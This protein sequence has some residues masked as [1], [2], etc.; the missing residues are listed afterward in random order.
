MK[1]TERLPQLG[2]KILESGVLLKRAVDTGT[3]SLYAAKSWAGS[4][5]LE[6]A[7]LAELREYEQQIRD[8][9]AACDKGFK[10]G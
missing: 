1:M 2:F 8:A 5:I 9:K 4:N 7:G 6:A 3:D 10:I